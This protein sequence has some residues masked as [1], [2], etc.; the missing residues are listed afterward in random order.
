MGAS[1]KGIT[2]RNM[3]TR[4]AA[5]FAASALL[6]SSVASAD[7]L[8]NGDFSLGGDSWDTYLDASADAS[9]DFGADAATSTLNTSGS[10]IWHVQLEQGGLT[11]EQGATY[12][13]FVK[14]G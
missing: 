7:M 4:I 14:E 1:Y 13:R 3:K 12:V 9:I 8:Q 6:A 5:A 10:E 2:G 11:I